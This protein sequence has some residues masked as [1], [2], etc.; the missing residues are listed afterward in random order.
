M[1]ELLI[2][3]RLDRSHAQA[4]ANAQIADFKKVGDAAEDAGRRQQKA[5]KDAGTADQAAAKAKLEQIARTRKAQADAITDS[6]GRMRTANGQFVAGM[7][8]SQDATDQFAASLKGVGAGAVGLNLV[9]Q[10]GQAIADTM[11]NA[12]DYADRLA[13]DFI[14]QRD[15][16][17]E[18]AAITGGQSNNAS[19]L[20][21][22]RFNSQT[23]FKPNESIGFV[24]ELLNAGNQNI[25]PGK[26]LS[27]AQGEQFKLLAGQYAVAKGVDPTTMGS[28]AGSSLGFQNFQ[29]KGQ[30]ANEA[31]NSL[32]RSFKVMEA[33]QGNGA[34]MARQL[35]MLAASSVG[36]DNTFKTLEDAAIAVSV[37][38]EK[39]DAQSA[40]MVMASI[41]GLR[42]FKN[43]ALKAAGITPDTP[44]LDSVKKMGDYVD[45][46][47][48]ATGTKPTDLLAGIFT[49][50]LTKTGVETFINRGQKGG[51]IA[52]RQK[53]LGGMNDPNAAKK[54]IND[55]QNDPTGAGQNRIAEAQKVE[56]EMNRGSERA[57]LATLRTQAET[58]FEAS[59]LE[60]NGL[61][62]VV[63]GAGS[64]ASKVTGGL[65]RDPKEEAIRRTMGIILDKRR[66]AAGLGGMAS[67]ETGFLGS[68]Y[69]GST[70]GVGEDQ[71]MIAALRE[72]TDA[73]KSNG[74]AGA[75]K[76]APKPAAPLP[77]PL[78]GAPPVP[79][80]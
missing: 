46:E 60:D 4:G 37:G 78:A 63:Q 77:P 19:T 59:R 8:R 34:V 17:R 5:A 31:M 72:L 14:A 30:G 47:S 33:G 80:R 22:A 3:L 48:A 40:E 10:A 49:D 62:S 36:P 65:L 9:A 39:H 43:P 68:L 42:D 18:I 67:A 35:Q 58:A 54:L 53:I 26:S 70:T 32:N 44:F 20:A 79:T 21:M 45:K 15:A 66:A 50:H 74:M 64:L 71:A 29:N 25:G 61:F 73:I 76:V 55:F 69:G 52:D 2:K 16:L 28:I 24:T 13:K 56:E 57:A 11:K 6:A 7:K 75:N 1:K 41:R 51:V 38:A 12:R 23:G 27:G